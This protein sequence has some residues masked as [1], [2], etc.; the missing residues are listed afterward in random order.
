MTTSHRP[1][2]RRTG[3]LLLCLWGFGLAAAPP[4]WAQGPDAPADKAESKPKSDKSESKN[5]SDKTG[6]KKE[7]PLPPPRPA[8]DKEIDLD[9]TIE[10]SLPPPAP[11][12]LPKQM[13]AIDLGCVLRLAGV[14]NPDML[15][16]RARVA[17]A[18]AL[19]FYAAAFV[20]PS[21]NAGL[22][23]DDHNGPLQQSSG[24]ILTVNR[25][26]LYLGMGAGAV[27]AGTVGVPGVLY[28]VNLSNSL[29]NLFAARY[30]LR[31]READNIAVRNQMLLR[32]ATAYMELVRAEAQ[33]KIAIANQKLAHEVARLTAVHAAV[34]TGNKADANRAASEL[35]RR[36]QLIV[37]AE[38]AILVAS[39]N[40]VALLN[41]PP[42]I[43]MHAID[44]WV[45]PTEIVPLALPLQELIFIG[46]QQRPELAARRNEIRAAVMN[47]RRQI[48]IPLTPTVLAGYSSGTFGGGSNLVAYPGGF[49][50]FK[51][52]YFGSFAPRQDVDVVMFWTAQNLGI[53]NLGR[54][55]VARAERDIARFEYIRALNQMRDDVAVAYARIHANYAEIDIARRG[56][57]A[58]LRGYNED[59]QRL[60]QRT[61][62]LPIE[63]LNNFRL[64]AAARMAYLDAVVNYDIA[65][66]DMFVALG[67]PPTNRL[68]RAI[69][70]S[71]DIP[72][73][74]ESAPPFPACVPPGK[75]PIAHLAGKPHP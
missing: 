75:G 51:E 20:L 16:A 17:R 59:Y 41:I 66:F 30:N 47:L 60:T 73:K 3:L 5:K 64:L 19:R 46:T 22:N 67:Q 24:N 14:Y 11:S 26:A 56:M 43:Q 23:Y 71:K 21:L 1:H 70:D 44:G 36:N 38:Q 74:P 7:E 54:I 13:N 50:G 32:V 42:S 63:L 31:A 45:L 12:I 37:E 55:R 68:A 33:R 15:I 52:P 57:E 39:A 6:S 27:A 4:L 53:G 61:G 28:N 34:G 2:L 72:T 18:A 40:L 10:A 25:Q 48:F 9:P 35:A 58:A 49:Q 29:F 62:V 8:A 65:Q 69:P